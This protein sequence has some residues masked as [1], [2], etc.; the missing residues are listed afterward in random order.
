MSVV[1]LA[2]RFTLA[3]VFAVAGAAKLVDLAGSRRAVLGFGVPQR[4]AAPI[5][6]LL[7]VG[8][9]AVAVAL[10]VSGSARGGAVGAL[11]LLGGFIVAITLALAKG[12][13]PDCHCFGQLR[14]SPVGW[15]TLARNLALAAVA[16]LVVIGG[17]GVSATSWLGGLGAV[18][19]AGLAGGLL[20]L[21][22]AAVQGAFSYQLLRQNGRLIARVSTLEERLGV[23][24]AQ[25]AG[26]PV[27]DPAP[28][29]ALAG[30][31]GQL[32]SLDSLRARGQ[33]VMLVFTNPGCGPC[34][35]L[36][37]EVAGWQQ[38]H[39]ER[40]TV[41][42]ITRGTL[43]ESQAYGAEHSLG[44]LLVQVDHEV[45]DAYQTF[46]TPSAQLVTVAGAI[47]SPLAQGAV[48]IRTLLDPVFEPPTAPDTQSQAIL[49]VLQ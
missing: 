28:G 34:E 40:L 26:L 41:A 21:C 3:A 23:S 16:A 29:F 2:S 25:A 32:V 24:G 11:V 10:L 9:L 31:D 14:S 8:E 6:T 15:P 19:L 36:L 35:A 46:G 33:P 27:G 4:L 5:G 7:P 43:S 20:L 13:E 48:E 44:E 37:P 12:R 45:A 38:Q 17:P 1:W 39:A 18:G 49:E 47:A 30:L 22:L 42:L